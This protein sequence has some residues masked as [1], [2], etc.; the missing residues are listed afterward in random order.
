MENK[1]ESDVDKINISYKPNFISKG[2][3]DRYFK[4]LNEEVQYNSEEESKIEIFGKKISIPR[5]Q[6]GYGDEGTYYSFSG[7][8]VI[9]KSWDEND[10]VCIMLKDVKKRVEKFTGLTFNFVL[11]NRYENGDQ[12]IGYHRDDEKEL[13]SEPNIVGVS[14]GAEREIYFKPHKFIPHKMKDP[15]K[16]KLEH[17]SVFVMHHPTNVHWKHSIPK[18]STIKTPRISLTFRNLII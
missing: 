12:Y 3:S 15:T 7:V 6:V 4:I 14:F 11:I 17:G 13:G 8:K 16:L 9:A 1:I 5:K 10:N 18:K 2:T